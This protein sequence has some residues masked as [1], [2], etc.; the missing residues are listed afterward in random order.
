MPFVSDLSAS[1]DSYNDTTVDL[2]ESCTPR[3]LHHGDLPVLTKRLAHESVELTREDRNHHLN[4][5]LSVEGSTCSIDDNGS[6]ANKLHIPEDTNAESSIREDL[7]HLK[8]TCAS[9]NDFH[10]DKDGNMHNNHGMHASWKHH[11]EHGGLLENPKNLACSTNN[12]T[13]GPH[14]ERNGGSGNT[15]ETLSI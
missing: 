15:V 2:R 3:I 7:H 11:F 1:C 13:L 4:P 12:A 6:C 8:N 5:D 9:S 14:A 10:I